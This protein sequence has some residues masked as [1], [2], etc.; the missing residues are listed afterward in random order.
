MDDPRKR[1]SG[2]GRSITPVPILTGVRKGDS[3][4]FGGDRVGEPVPIGPGILASQRIESR[5]GDPARLSLDMTTT[6]TKEPA[7]P[8]RLLTIIEVSNRLGVSVRHVRRLVF[9]QR[10][11]YVKWGH[12]VRFDPIEIE[13]W[14]D[15]ARS[16][17]AALPSVAPRKPP[18]A[19]LA[20][21]RRPSAP[22]HAEHRSR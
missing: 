9:E 13:R 19:G 7:R 1:R 6:V 3:L 11:P 18:R 8:D 22:S 14:I 15:D 2:A 21:T 5:S 16:P 10:V 4:R 20:A 12:L 17:T